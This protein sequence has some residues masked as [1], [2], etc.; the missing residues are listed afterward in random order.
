[1]A[2]GGV[3]FRGEQEHRPGLLQDAGELSG[4]GIDVD[5]ELGQHVGATGA[6]G[7]GAIAVL[8]H[9]HAGTR[10]DKGD[11]G[12]DVEG[13]GAIAAGAADVDG[14]SRGL[15]GDHAGAHGA[16]GAG[17]FGDGFAADA[18]GHE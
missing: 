7:E 9:R 13:G 10:E 17:Q 14:V 5:A 12:R 1:M 8:G 2:Q 18:H 3:V 16:D 11:G 6:A 4:V 15:D